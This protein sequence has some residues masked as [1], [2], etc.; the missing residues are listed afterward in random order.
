MRKFEKISYEEFKKSLGDDKAL[1]DSITLP[2][3]SS[4]FSAGY[5]V[6][7]IEHGII[8]SGKSMA[9]KTGLKV[10]M[11]EDEV[12]YIYSRSSFGY[13]YDVCLTNC[14][15]VIDSDYYNNP[16][17]EGHFQVKLTNHGDKDFEINIGDRIGQCVF[18]KYLVVDDEEEITE[19][20]KGGLGSTGKGE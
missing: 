20:R 6:K 19:K 17:N 10:A 12:M 11:N 13:K 3:R 2:K 8:K 15:G 16:D 4:K 5:D 14:V 1:Y 18:M 7:S 9:F